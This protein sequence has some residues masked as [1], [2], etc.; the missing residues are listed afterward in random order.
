MLFEKIKTMEEELNSKKTEKV[1]QK[2]ENFAEI[3]GL[4]INTKD[5]F[6]EILFYFKRNLDHKTF[7]KIYYYFYQV[8]NKNNLTQKQKKK[9]VSHTKK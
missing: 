8:L 5:S 3:N 7:R 4:K 1:K 2:C 6:E 9:N